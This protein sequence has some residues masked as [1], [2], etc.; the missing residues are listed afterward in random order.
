[1]SPHTPHSE[2]SLDAFVDGELTPGERMIVHAEIDR[3][4][5]LAEEVCRMREL[6][7]LVRDA[8]QEVP[9]PPSQKPR[10]A[11]ASGHLWRR[12]AVAVLCFLLGGTVSWLLQGA[13]LDLPSAA[14]DAT[15]AGGRVV[16]ADPSVLAEVTATSAPVL[17]HLSS[18]DPA[19]MDQAL[20]E[21]EALARQD[22]HHRVELVVNGGG[23]D[24]IRRDGSPYAERVEAL[25]A[26][27][28]NVTILACSKALERWRYREGREPR[29]LKGVEVAPSAL[30]L[31]VERLKEGWTYVR[32]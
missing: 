10:L 15:P 18:A 9:P 3:D 12:A 8:Y 28:G 6:K 20:D 21:L 26:T 24:L 32:I 17:L 11:E 14:A 4:P 30:D 29:L 31:V 23:L 22:L 19:K 27:Y 1:M 25:L 13:H 5:R 16:I 2:S 7:A